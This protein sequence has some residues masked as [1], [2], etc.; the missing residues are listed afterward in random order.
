MEYYS[1]GKFSKLI[2]K[3]AHTLREWDKEGELKPYH[4]TPSVYR[5]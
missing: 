2:G 1:I 5:Y 4:I 3:N